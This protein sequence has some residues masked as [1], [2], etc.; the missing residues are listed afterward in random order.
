MS[1]RQTF[2]WNKRGVDYAKQRGRIVEP[3][4]VGSG[5]RSREGFTQKRRKRAS[6]G[7]TKSVDTGPDS[8]TVGSIGKK[9]SMEN[10]KGDARATLG[11]TASTASG[12]ALSARGLNGKRT[13]LQ[14]NFAKETPHRGCGMS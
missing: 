10:R 2:P 1:K 8:A 9:K 3:R 5:N 13:S 7:K 12:A 6:K 14:K 11:R 4:Y